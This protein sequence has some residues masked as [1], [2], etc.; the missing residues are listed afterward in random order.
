M[1]KFGSRASDLFLHGGE[2]QIPGPISMM[3]VS[4]AGGAGGTGGAVN[5]SNSQKTPKTNPKQQNTRR[6]VFGREG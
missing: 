4:A 1:V 2:L 6:N 5:P 3:F